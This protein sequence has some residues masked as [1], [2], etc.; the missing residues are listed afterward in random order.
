MQRYVTCVFS[1]FLDGMKGMLSFDTTTP[2]W[3]GL[4]RNYYY[5][6]LLHQMAAQKQTCSDTA[7]KNEKYTK[8]RRIIKTIKSEPEYDQN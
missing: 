6:S 5:Y 3:M 4:G 8:Q 7:V 2:V 1:H